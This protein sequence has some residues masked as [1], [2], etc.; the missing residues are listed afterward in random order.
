MESNQT[1]LN[2]QHVND[3]VTCNRGRPMDL[4]GSPVRCADYQLSY[5]QLRERLAAAHGLLQEAA[6]AKACEVLCT[7]G[8]YQRAKEACGD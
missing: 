6:A 8:W 4:S 7:P 1:C 5:D 3:H 2:C